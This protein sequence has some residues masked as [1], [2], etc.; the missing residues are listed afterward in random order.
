MSSPTPSPTSNSPL[1]PTVTP[2]IR[3]EYL[4]DKQGTPSV[5]PASWSAA[6]LGRFAPRDFGLGRPFPHDHFTHDRRRSHLRTR[7]D[8]LWPDHRAGRRSRI[9]YHHRPAGVEGA[10]HRARR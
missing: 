1:K 6:V 5:A 9:P 10:N 8:L 3:H 2:E 7:H 4:F